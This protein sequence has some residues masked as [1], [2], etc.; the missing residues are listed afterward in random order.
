MSPLDCGRFRVE[1]E[2]ALSGR[3]DPGAVAHLAW[4]SHLSECAGCRALL[5]GEEALEVLLASLPQP[6]LPQELAQRVL[7][8]LS[9]RSDALD[10][11]LALDAAPPS[12]GLELSGRV[13]GE[14]VD[15]RAEAR[16]DA[17]LELEAEPSAPDA[18]ATD[19]LAGLRPA[20]EEQAVEEWLEADAVEQPIRLPERVLAGLESVRERTPR[21]FA[22]LAGGAPLLKLAALVLG[23]LG[24]AW[25]LR[26]PLGSGRGDAVDV[27]QVPSVEMLNVLDVLTEDW[28][29]LMDQELE[30][31][32]ALGSLSEE[33]S[34]W[35]EAAA[36]VED[37]EE[38]GR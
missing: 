32:A 1:L 17:L 3:P 37:V 23:L 25:L 38:Q 19:V 15:A 21:R 30:L 7:A 26:G 4:K 24:V 34:L 33:D 20:R 31:D 16:L 36:A 2:R 8:R 18:L 27:A 14:L 13:L 35:L 29:L 9:D 11:L 12:A 6:H 28:E 10:E 22:L 5:E